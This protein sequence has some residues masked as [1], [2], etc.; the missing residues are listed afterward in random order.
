M[1]ELDRPDDSPI[2]VAV[3]DSTRIHSQ[4]L[5]E[6][7]KRDRHLD[8]VG[9]VSTSRELLELATR[10]P[11][12]VAVINCTLEDQA[13]RGFEILRDLQRVRPVRGV[14]LLDSSKPEMVV[15][16]FRAGAKGIFSKHE[17]LRSLCK[18][19]RRVHE[20]QI[21]ANSRELSYALEA[22][23]SAQRPIRAVDSKGMALLSARE[24]QVVQAV[25]EGLTNREIGE[26]LK[27]S[28]HTVKNYLL[29]IYDKVG[30]SSRME[31]LW[32]ILSKP[33]PKIDGPRVTSIAEAG[34]RQAISSEKISDKRF[35][36]VSAD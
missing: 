11:L 24:Q 35:A 6:A 8:V 23:S 29:R 33:E 10:V 12:Q 15:E 30:V 25:A 26:R 16:A 28:R 1:Q 18:C 4:L 2:L 36:A 17:S 9:A 27:L 13:V 3:A 22:L 34:R 14:F 19:V 21:W 5:A 7:L 31:L 32:L 20:G